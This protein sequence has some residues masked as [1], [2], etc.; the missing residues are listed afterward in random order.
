MGKA[1]AGRFAALDAQ[2]L[3]DAA[4]AV[5]ASE[6]SRVDLRGQGPDGPV[7]LRLYT[8]Q[9]AGRLR[10]DVLPDKEASRP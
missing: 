9:R 1:K 7:Q 8:M 10:I 5:W 2:E 4:L 3:H 6:A